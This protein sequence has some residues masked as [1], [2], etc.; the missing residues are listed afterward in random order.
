[1]SERERSSACFKR[2]VLLL[3]LVVGLAMAYSGAVWGETVGQVLQSRA[4]NE[5]WGRTGA[6]VHAAAVPQ[7]QYGAQLPGTPSQAPPRP[8]V[9]QAPAAPVVGQGSGKVIAGPAGTNVVIVKPQGAIQH[10]AVAPA[11]PGVR[12]RPLAPQV[13]ASIAQTAAV[14]AQSSSGPFV[15]S[16]RTLFIEGRGSI[17]LR[18]PANVDA[19]NDWANMTVMSSPAIKGA[20]DLIGAGSAT[21]KTYM[22]HW[23]LQRGCEPVQLGHVDA[24]GCPIHRSGQAGCPGR[25]RGGRSARAHQ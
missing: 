8:G 14:A 7:G 16:P 18:W 13:K 6:S 4:G 9:P 22:V 5:V 1:M 11:T 15:L 21:T 20:I 3:L 24:R 17:I 19:L 10:S 2:V 12:F 25:C 23:Q